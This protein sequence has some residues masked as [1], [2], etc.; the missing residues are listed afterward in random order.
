LLKGGNGVGKS[1][2]LG[3]LAAALEQANV[4]VYKIENGGADLKD[5]LRQAFTQA[6]DSASKS[7]HRSAVV[8]IDDIDVVAAVNSPASIALVDEMG[9]LEGTRVMLVATA[10]DATKLAQETVSALSRQ[11]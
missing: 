9:K 11:Q 1:H 5:R 3:D 8:M 10:T 2:V 6:R 4:P 7:L